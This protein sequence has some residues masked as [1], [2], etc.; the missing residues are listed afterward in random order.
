[1]TISTQIET[2]KT[3]DTSWACYTAAGNRR[4]T[5]IVTMM[6]SMV[7]SGVD[8]SEACEAM[9]KK[10]YAACGT[11]MGRAAGMIDTEVRMVL[12]D[13]TREFI[14]ETLDIDYYD[15]VDIVEK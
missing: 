13:W 7:E 8:P 2:Q 4:I 14:A 6:V 3:I 1:M 10:Y 12:R 9:W 15:A 5:K 11:K